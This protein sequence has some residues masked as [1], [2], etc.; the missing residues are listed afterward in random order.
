[1]ETIERLEE[2]FMWY[3]ARWA[4]QVEYNNKLHAA[5]SKNR[6][7]TDDEIMRAIT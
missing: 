3:K 7:A 2:K 4:E 6:G 5:V 1:M